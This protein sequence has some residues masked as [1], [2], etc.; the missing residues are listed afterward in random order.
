MTDTTDEAVAAL[1]ADLD[2]F[3][4]RTGWGLA[5]SRD[6]LRRGDLAAAR[7]RFDTTRRHVEAMIANGEY[8]PPPH[9][10][11]TTGRNPS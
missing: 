5:L 2:A 3:T 4:A 10:E 7:R 1:W 11:T 9:P 8:E 6:L